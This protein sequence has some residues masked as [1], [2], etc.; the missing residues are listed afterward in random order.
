LRR[1]RREQQE[2]NLLRKGVLGE[3]GGGSSRKE[4]L[5]RCERYGRRKCFR[6]NFLL[7]IWVALCAYAK[8]EFEEVWKGRGMESR[9]GG[10]KDFWLFSKKE[11]SEVGVC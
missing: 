5:Y 2:G 3:K 1:L 4:A 9:G 8:G 7:I 6:K 10:G 11:P